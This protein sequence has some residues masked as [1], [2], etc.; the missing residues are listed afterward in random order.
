MADVKKQATRE[1]YGEALAEIGHKYDN[2]IVLDADLSGPKPRPSKKSS[3]KDFLI[4]VLPSRTLS[5]L[6]R[7]LLPRENL[8]FAAPLQ[9][10][11]RDAPLSRSETQ[12]DT[13]I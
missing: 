6:Q 10:L 5:A 2:L 3:P 4:A 7:V 12:L 13:L 8:C 1:A 9:C 11:L